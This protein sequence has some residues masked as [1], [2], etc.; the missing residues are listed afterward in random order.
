MT[1]RE[2][3]RDEWAC[4]LNTVPCTPDFTPLNGDTQVKAVF[5]DNRTGEV[6]AAALYESGSAPKYY[7]AGGSLTEADAP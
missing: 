3:T 7:V 5:S 6:V 2:V 1:L 4:A